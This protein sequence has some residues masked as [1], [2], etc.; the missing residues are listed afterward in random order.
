MRSPRAL[1]VLLLAA[2]LALFSSVIAAAPA[3]GWTESPIS[4]AVGGGPPGA[5]LHGTLTRPESAD[6]ADAVLIQPGSGPVD[7]D[8]NAPGTARGR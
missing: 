4:L 5:A 1:P 2:C 3:A 6:T 7:R 8:G